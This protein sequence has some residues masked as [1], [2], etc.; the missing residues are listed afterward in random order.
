MALA[1]KEKGIAQKVIGV[2]R[3]APTPDETTSGDDTGSISDIASGEP[4]GAPSE[5]SARSKRIAGMLDEL[6][7]T[8]ESFVSVDGTNLC[9]LLLCRQC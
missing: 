4:S 3:N 9:V 2:G 7:D 1:L 5:L 6:E 8:C